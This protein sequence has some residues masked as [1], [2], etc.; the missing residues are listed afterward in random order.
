MPIFGRQKERSLFRRAG[1][2]TL[3]TITT[4]FGWMTVLNFGF[5]LLTVG[6]LLAAR[7]KIAAIHAGMFGMEPSDVEKAYFA[8]LGNYKLLTI[9][10]CLTSYITLKL[11]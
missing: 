7:N 10:F 11:M 4:F 6:I 8:Y 2:M 5:L 9:F 1:I 3:A